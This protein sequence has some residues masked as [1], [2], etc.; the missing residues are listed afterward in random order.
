MRMSVHGQ[1]FSWPWTEAA[2]INNMRELADTIGLEAVHMASAR[3][4]HRPA[5]Q[6]GPEALQEAP[7]SPDTSGSDDLACRAPGKAR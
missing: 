4:R 2:A 7:F 5:P 1:V 3:M 6:P